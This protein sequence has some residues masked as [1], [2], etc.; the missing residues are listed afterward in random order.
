[1]RE[2]LDVCPQTDP[3]R[4]CRWGNAF[5]DGFHAFIRVTQLIPQLVHLSGNHE[6]GDKD[7]SSLAPAQ[8]FVGICAWKQRS[9]AAQ[10]HLYVT[11]SARD[12]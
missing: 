12:L 3:F 9:S 11:A 8:S 2:P 10:R 5:A 6:P 1:M 7:G 4:V